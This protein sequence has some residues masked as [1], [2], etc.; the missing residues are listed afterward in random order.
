MAT[1]RS[2]SLLLL[3]LLSLACVAQ[4]APSAASGGDVAV[5]QKTLIEHVMPR[6][7][8]VGKPTPRFE[9]TGIDGVETYEIRIENEVEVE[10]FAQTGIK[11]TSV[12]WPADLRLEPGTY[13]WRITGSKGGRM[14]ADSGR[15]AFLIHEP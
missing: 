12:P 8:Y 14:I 7:D 10:M 11:G 9:W 1:F 5:I 15:A 13:F 4:P 2:K 3:A 6:R